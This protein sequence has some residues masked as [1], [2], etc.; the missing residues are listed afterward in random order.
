MVTFS[1]LPLERVLHFSIYSVAKAP[2]SLSNFNIPT[3]GLT[4][5]FSNRGCLHHK[6]R[7]AYFQNFIAEKMM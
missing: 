2:S 7:K 3:E 1:V 5:N 6:L 4:A